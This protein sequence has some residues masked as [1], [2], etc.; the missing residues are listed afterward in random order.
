MPNLKDKPSQSTPV[1]SNYLIMITNPVTGAVT[2]MTLAEFLNA[3]IAPDTTPPS[4]V[5]A[6][7]INSTLI[8]VI[9][10][11]VIPVGSAVGWSAKL[12]GANNP[13]VSISGFGTAT[14][15]ITV[16]NAMA[17]GDAIRISYNPA[18]GNSLDAAGNE[19]GTITDFVVSNA[20]AGGG[21]G[22]TTAPTV[23]SATVENAAKNLIVVVFSE[24]VSLTTAGWS[25]L[26]AGSNWPI[27]SV[28]GSGTT[29]TFTMTGDAANGETLQ[30][31]YNAVG[32]NTVDGASNELATFTNQ[33]VTNNVAAGPSFEFVV[34]TNATANITTGSNGSIDADTTSETIGARATKKLT[35]SFIIEAQCRADYLDSELAWLVLSSVNNTDFSNGNG[36][37][38]GVVASFTTYQQDFYKNPGP[39]TTSANQAVIGTDVIANNMWL[40]IERSGDNLLYYSS[41]DGTTYTLRNTSTDAFA[42]L[43]E[44]FIKFINGGGTGGYQAVRASGLATI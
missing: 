34:W 23:V 26:K 24:S 38:T 37:N 18:S 13:I 10:S 4:I 15:D 43:S 44:C 41:P 16:T 40:R 30:R 9:C 20:L 25:F 27:V 35:G 2:K 36:G 8:R 19:F 32:G 12:N 21:G 22:D 31:S 5:G 33:S 39:D 7:C 14:L 42:G 29:W 17:G 11:E 3:E 1:P 6:S 28:S